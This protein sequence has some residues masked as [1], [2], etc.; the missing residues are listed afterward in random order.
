MT[1]VREYSR[2]LYIIL[3]VVLYSLRHPALTTGLPELTSSILSTSNK[4]APPSQ[5]LAVLQSSADGLSRMCTRMITLVRW[6]NCT[7]QPKHE[8][9][10]YNIVPCANPTAPGHTIT[11]SHTG[12][13]TRKGGVCPR[14]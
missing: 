7:A 13:S 12:A 9:T 6:V 1:H 4:V 3:F 2:V 11:D 5:P 8:K 10:E 14:C